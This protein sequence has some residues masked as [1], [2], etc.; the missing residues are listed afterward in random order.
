[1]CGCVRGLL[2]DTTCHV[3]DVFGFILQAT[4]VVVGLH[5]R[6]YLTPDG[7]PQLGAERTFLEEENKTLFLGERT[8]LVRGPPESHHPLPSLDFLNHRLHVKVPK[9]GPRRRRQLHRPRREELDVGGGHTLTLQHT[10][11]EGRRVLSYHALVVRGHLFAVVGVQHAPRLVLLV[12]GVAEATAL[13]AVPG[14]G[15]DGRP[16]PL[17]GGRAD[18]S[19]V[20]RA[21][22]LNRG[23]E[24]GRKEGRREGRKWLYV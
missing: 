9:L 6:L 24:E 2:V 15:S 8:H 19:S 18:R 3:F 20:Q 10:R 5:T 1:M 22:E 4:V 16:V 7:G 12:A 17:G 13:A 21:G 14:A 23:Q 11:G